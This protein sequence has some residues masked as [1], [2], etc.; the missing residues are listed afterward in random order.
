MQHD[1]DET[2]G[3]TPSAVD[4][5]SSNAFTEFYKLTCNDL[6]GFDDEE[7]LDFPR[8]QNLNID[9]FAYYT[10]DKF[11]ERIK[12][13]I[14]ADF[15]TLHINVRGLECNYDNFIMLLH[16]SSLLTPCLA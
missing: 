2:T 16:V 12:I 7:R 10:T 5:E 3:D 15:S 1:V 4:H 13:E 6:N 9:D 8:F 14:G 11:N